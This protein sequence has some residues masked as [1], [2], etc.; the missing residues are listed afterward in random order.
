[1]VKWRRCFVEWEIRK[2]PYALHTWNNK[3][4]YICIC[5]CNSKYKHV[6][7][8][9]KLLLLAV[10]GSIQ[11]ASIYPRTICDVIMIKS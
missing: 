11:I 6:V 10:A 3:Y 7:N 2:L 4:L 9:G 8:C 1:M 5:I